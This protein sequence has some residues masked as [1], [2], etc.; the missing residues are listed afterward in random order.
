MNE[1]KALFQ[2]TKHVESCPKCHAPLQIKRGKQGL[3]LGCSQ[4]P[5]CD[6]IKP[7]QQTVRVIKMLAETC[8]ECGSLLQLKQGHFGIFIGCSQYPLCHF[9]VHEEKAPEAT[10]DCPNCKKHKLVARQGR[11]G[12]TFYGCSGFPHCKFTLPSKPIEI[13][14]PKCQCPLAI[15]K[16]GRGKSQY[17]C[18]NKHCQ[19][20]FQ[21]E[22]QQ[23]QDA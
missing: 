23:N 9:S 3:F 6:Y 4:Y 12:R 2:S 5:D 13:T 22:N 19:H 20:L 21:D 14:C 8:P 17:Q 11:N 10:W 16:K 1:S 7:L 15:E 18:A